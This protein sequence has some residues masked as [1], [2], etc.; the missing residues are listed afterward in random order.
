MI[1]ELLKPYR[2]LLA[3]GSP[4]RKQL[5]TGLDVDFEVVKQDV[6]ESFSSDLVRGEIPQYLALKKNR[7]FTQA[8]DQDIVIT[9]DTVVWCDGKVLNKPEDRE[10]AIAMLSML[11]GKTHQVFTGVCI[12]LGDREIAFSDETKVT[13]SKIDQDEIA[14]YLDQY[15]PYD[16]AGSYGAQDWLGY[17]AIDKLEGSYYNVMGFPV[18]KVYRALKEIAS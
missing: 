13:F 9:A 14:Y 1:R 18:R 6:D 16:K 15:K 10:E 17:V 2:I 3:S 12:R 8:G 11:S 7:A 5:L 4:R